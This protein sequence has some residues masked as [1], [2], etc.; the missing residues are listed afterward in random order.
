MESTSTVDM[1]NQLERNNTMSHFEEIK[2][3]SE[4]NEPISPENSYKPQEQ[5]FLPVA[6][7]K[8][9]EQ[10][11]EPEI[12]NLMI[13]FSNFHKKEKPKNP[14]MNNRKFSPTRIKTSRGRQ[15][16]SSDERFVCVRRSSVDET[17]HLKRLS[18]QSRNLFSSFK[19][20]INPIPSESIFK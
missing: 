5:T 10:Q 4:E 13:P 11:N 3:V 14:K 18:N 2:E 19:R 12:K 15:S 7:V 17:N 6:G 1:L 16:N 9:H 8:L 20:M